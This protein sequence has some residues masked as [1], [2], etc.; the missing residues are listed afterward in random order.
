VPHDFDAALGADRGELV[1]GALEA[2]ERVRDTRCNDIEGKVVF[3][4]ANFA[5]SHDSP[6]IISG[7]AH[8]KGGRTAR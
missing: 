3:V 2:V 8:K 1:N 6:R 4:A 7:L 5:L